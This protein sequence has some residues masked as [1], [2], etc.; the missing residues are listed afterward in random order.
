MKMHHYIRFATPLHHACFT[1]GKEVCQSNKTRRAK[2]YAN[3]IKHSQLRNTRQ[4][5]KQISGQCRNYHLVA[6]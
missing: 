3:P 6:V 2:K 1:T 5:F 4:R